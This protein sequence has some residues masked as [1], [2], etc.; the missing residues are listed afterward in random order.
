MNAGLSHSL[1]G[2]HS[3]VWELGELDPASG[4]RLFQS[5][6]PAQL[7]VRS[8]DLDSCLAGSVVRIPVSLW[9][10]TP[11]RDPAAPD[12][13]KDEGWGPAELR[14]PVALN[15]ACLLVLSFSSVKWGQ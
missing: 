6:R 5:R 4:F 3:V 1:S 9:A 7:S 13:V 10:P 12:T 14:D 15:L 2:F 11:C 8:G